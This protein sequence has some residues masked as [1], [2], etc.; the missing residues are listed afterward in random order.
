MGKHQVQEVTET[1]G[2]G[3]R[4][5]MGDLKVAVDNLDR[6]ITSSPGR[7]C[8]DDPRIQEQDRLNSGPEPEGDATGTP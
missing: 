6:L 8:F 3:L 2:K 1:E 5:L 4:E 7:H